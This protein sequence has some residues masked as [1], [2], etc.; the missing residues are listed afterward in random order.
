MNNPL[1]MAFFRRLSILLGILLALLFQVPA[2]AQVP[3]QIHATIFG[4]DNRSSFETS[5]E[6]RA[7]YLVGSLSM[8]TLRGF[9]EDYCTAFLI[10]ERY[11][12]TALHCVPFS[13]AQ[14]AD[15]LDFPTPELMLPFLL[16]GEVFFNL[17]RNRAVHPDYGLA[18]SRVLT[19]TGLLLTGEDALPRGEIL[20]LTS[21][22]NVQGMAYGVSHPSESSGSPPPAPGAEGVHKEAKDWAVLELEVPL[23]RQYGWFSLGDAVSYVGGSEVLSVS[24]YPEGFILSRA[25]LCIRL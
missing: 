15:R 12:L 16:D 6:N 25:A 18:I 17:D 10:G 1:L 20:G 23:G 21:N 11:I 5:P 22:P 2:Y 24:G 4:F 19:L 7:S 3:G 9:E 14:A 13:K 8:R